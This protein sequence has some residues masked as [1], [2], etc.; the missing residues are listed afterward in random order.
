VEKGIFA[1]IENWKQSG[2][3]VFNDNVH[4]QD[5]APSEYDDEV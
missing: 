5:T 1:A 3:P 2:D 4:H